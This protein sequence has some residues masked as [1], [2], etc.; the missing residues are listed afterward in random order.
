MKIDTE[1]MTIRVPIGTKA[2]LKEAA[3][4]RGTKSATM[5]N[6][7]FL[8]LLEDEV[9]E[10]FAQPPATEKP[11]MHRVH[12]WIPEFLRDLYARRAKEDGFKPATWVSYL[13]QQTLMRGVV[14]TDAELAIVR[15]SSREL[16]AVGRNLNQ[17]AR[18]INE[19][20]AMGRNLS[21]AGQLR[22]QHLDALKEA[23]EVS[24]TRI[25]DLVAHRNRAWS[26]HD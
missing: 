8:A 9:A 18:A 24:R 5:V 2:K 3:H 20:V 19:E 7:L 13:V 10:A 21:A 22:M 12:F 4:R 16:A 11:T 26:P 17:I 1:V 6:A 15:E 23:I 14:I 25:D